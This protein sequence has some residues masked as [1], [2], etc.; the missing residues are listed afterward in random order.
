MS[1]FLHNLRN[2]TLSNRNDK[3]RKTYDN[4]QYRPTDRNAGRD[5]R[6]GPQRKP[7]PPDQMTLVKKILE[8]IQE[9]QKELVKASRERAV[10]EKRM[11]TALETIAAHLFQAPAAAMPDTTPV[12]GTETSTAP[13]KAAP[14]LNTE[15]TE[16]PAK[17]A[18]V[19]DTEKAPTPAEAA[20]AL[21]PETAATRA[22]SDPEPAV[23]ASPDRLE[24]ALTLIRGMRD[25][26]ITYEKIARQLETQGVPTV[27]GRGKWRGQAV[28]KLL[29]EA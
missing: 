26:G 15:A 16:T 14:V 19:Q 21:D 11:A 8:E 10:A 28:S 12:M 1:D 7:Y 29:A 18:A 25:Q 4:N 20:P 2:G 3:P 13:I 5:K 9:S 17:T 24:V 22:E 23:E 27:S 6:N